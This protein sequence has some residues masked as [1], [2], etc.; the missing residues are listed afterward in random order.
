VA[1]LLCSQEEKLMYGPAREIWPA[2]K[3]G[4]LARKIN[5]SHLEKC[6]QSLGGG[7][8]EEGRASKGGSTDVSGGV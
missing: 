3:S 5:A 7:V 2:G 6:N 1:A 4:E 8:E